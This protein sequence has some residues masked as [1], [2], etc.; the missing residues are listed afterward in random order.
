MIAR[1][2]TP[3][4]AATVAAAVMALLI[5]ALGRGLPGFA[6]EDSDE[7][8]I[9]PTSALQPDEIKELP[10][11]TG[12]VVTAG[13]VPVEWG[14]IR[15][16]P[17]G[18]VPEQPDLQVLAPDR[19]QKDVRKDN[20]TSEAECEGF[21][22]YAAPT[23]LPEGF[24]L[25]SCAQETIVWD[26]N[27]ELTFNYYASFYKEGYFPISL[28]RQITPPNSMREVVLDED[29]SRF[30]LSL[31]TIAGHEAV[32]LHHSGEQPIQGP[33][34][35]YV[36]DGDVYTYLEAAGVDANQLIDVAASLLGD[37]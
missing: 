9:S 14:R 37:E 36:F 34:E 4:L 28:Y 2:A 22:L 27:S 6:N 23:R 20:G 8:K 5:L 25:T 33:F 26:D 13:D 7:P 32:V 11:P 18:S 16:L 15:V 12:T 29:N 24:T 10:T 1:L 21:D 3:V 17:T 31:V 30:S 35:V 19:T